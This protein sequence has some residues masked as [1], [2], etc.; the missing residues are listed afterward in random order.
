MSTDNNKNKN[1]KKRPT[2][3]R[4]LFG[5]KRQLSVLEEEE[6][7]SQFRTV[8]KRLF[9]K[10]INVVSLAIFL[11][12]FIF[13]LIGPFFRP[14]D[15]NYQEMTQQN[16]SPGY[17]LMKIPS[18]L[19][20]NIKEISVGSIFSLGL[21]NDGKVHV[22][23]KTAKSKAVDM[24][25]KIPKDMGNVVMISA[26]FDHAVAVN[27]KNE[28]FCWG[29][30]RLGQ[31]QVPTSINGKTV[32]Y[33]SAGYQGTV[34]IMDSGEAVYWGNASALDIDLSKYQ[35][36]YEKIVLT[37]NSAVA[38]TTDGEVVY[39]G[40]NKAIYS[41]IPE[42]E[43]VVDIAATAQTVCAILEDGSMKVWGNVEKGISEISAVDGR[44]VSVVAGRYH[45]TVLTDSG[46]VYSWGYNNFGQS[47]VP[48]KVN[49]NSNCEK[50]F[51]GYY[52]N[53]AL[54]SDGEV[55]TWGLKG[56]LF[57]SDQ[58][59]RDVF[60][61]LLAGGRMTMLIGSVAVIISTI[62]GVVFGGVSGYFGGKVDMVLMRIEEVVSALPFLPFA[63]I[64]S[65]I[66]GN[67]VN[68]TYRILIIMAILGLLSWTGLCRLV[69]AQVLA[70][71]EKEY[72]TAAKAMG[73]K[74]FALIIKHIIPNIISVIIVDMTLN[75]AGCMLTE[76]GL[77]Y[78]GFGVAEPK[79]TWGNMLTGCN[80]SVV[81][82][83]YW[84]RWIFPSIALGL[85]TIC[86]NVLGD[87]LRDAIDP[88]TEER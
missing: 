41:D 70:E 76:S 25:D 10:K 75:F 40:K 13:V 26:G 31:C 67:K 36:K 51:A 18:E 88:K 22:W 29:N 33:V 61:R 5:D 54:S 39:L 9:S 79:P 45:Y 11:S 20:G 52:Q 55:N 2:L 66:I 82:Q 69:R 59:G 50:I 19:K 16:V 43:R 38:L 46:N 23:G 73:V 53:Y 56:Y 27:D 49:K 32:K 30:D 78:L 17:N 37:A 87:G 57:G 28:V 71:R 24:K 6:M 21:S 85:S 81:I 15:V 60:L 65:A 34:L 84:W 68:E 77:S 64:L 48:S 7:E 44:P 1:N 62:I 12:I 63:M 3:L 47:N 35:G 8:V 14:L 58:Y 72:I 83:N 4:R 74:E 42:M 86:I 80:D